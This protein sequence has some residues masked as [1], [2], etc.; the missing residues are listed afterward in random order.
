MQF[1]VTTALLTL[2]LAAASALPYD[3]EWQYD[4]YW[5]QLF[6]G[7]VGRTQATEDRS[8]CVVVTESNNGKDYSVRI[9]TA[10][11]EG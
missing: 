11:R 9:C 6:A 4:Y 2:I 1:K 3:D 5:N 8:A 10:D 7:R